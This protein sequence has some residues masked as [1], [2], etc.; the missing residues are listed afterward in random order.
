MGIPAPVEI[1]APAAQ[2]EISEDE[3]ENVCEFCPVP[4]LPFPTEITLPCRHHAHEEC[5]VMKVRRDLG[6]KR[7]PRCCDIPIPFE[8]GLHFLTPEEFETYT[9]IETEG[10]T[11]DRTYCSNP[12]CCQF[13]PPDNI[14]D[15]HATCPSCRTVTCTTCKFERHDGEI[16]LQDPLLPDIL[17]MAESQGWQRC[18]KCKMMI[19]LVESSFVVE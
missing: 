8:F 11:L 19:E 16:C 4:S 9:A 5:L 18:Y 1:P 10:S 12:D 15:D 13:I 17:E 3:E 14:I 6:N 2:V 7:R